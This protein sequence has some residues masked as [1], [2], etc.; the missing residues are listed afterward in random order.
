[1]LPTY[2]SKGWIRIL[3]FIFPNLFLDN[4]F[5]TTD[6]TATHSP[7]Q[8]LHQTQP[9]N[10]LNSQLTVLLGLSLSIKQTD[11]ITPLFHYFIKSI[12][13]SIQYYFD[14]LISTPILPLLIY[15]LYKLLLLPLH[16]YKCCKNTI[17]LSNATVFFALLQSTR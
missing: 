6:L 11:N 3:F 14:S 8:L 5:I 1:M 10:Y 17:G 4:L 13:T 16:F 2:Y 9:A 12:L 7:S 15:F